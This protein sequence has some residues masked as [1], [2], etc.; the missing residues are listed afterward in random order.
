[1]EGSLLYYVGGVLQTAPTVEAGPPL[2]ISGI[3][4]PAGSNVTLLYEARVTEYAPLGENAS[5]EN[6]A[7]VDGTCIADPIIASAELPA[8]QEPSLT[9]SK[10]VSPETVGGCGSLTYTFVIQNTGSAAEEA[11]AIVVSDTFDP[12][13][14]NLIVELD[15]TELTL[16]TDYTYEEATGEF[17]TV[18]GRITVP[19]ADYT[20][21]T[22]GVF[23]VT[24]GNT[25][26]TIT[27]TI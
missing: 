23:T 3:T 16:G 11:A 22:Q 18:A 10:S 8:E 9:I 25:V 17:A 24:P 19:S 4:V 26:L 14:S 5:I 21:N 13:L 12:V 15:G 7:S 6:T 2:V 27:G 20:Q 1:M